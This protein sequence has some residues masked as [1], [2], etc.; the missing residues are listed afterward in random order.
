MIALEGIAPGLNEE[1]QLLGL[2]DPL[3]H[4]FESK[5][6]AVAMIAAT[7][8]LSYASPGISAKNERSI[9]RRSRGNILSVPRLE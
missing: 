6:F 9:L 8:A 2:L 7:I 3:R 1:S 5:V 4:G